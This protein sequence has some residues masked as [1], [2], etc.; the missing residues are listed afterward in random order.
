MH[1]WGARSV[2]FATLPEVPVLGNPLPIAR[3]WTAAEAWDQGGGPFRFVNTR[4]D[5]FH[6]LIRA[7]P[8]G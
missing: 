2:H 5:A 3:G 4:L 7:G 8:G 6:P 1:T